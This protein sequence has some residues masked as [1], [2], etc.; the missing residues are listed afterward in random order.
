MEQDSLEKVIK[1][2]VEW[3]KAQF[4]HA[5]QRSR[6]THLL[7]EAAELYVAPA[8]AMEAADIIFLAVGMIDEA[9]VDLLKVLRYKLEKNKKREWGKVDEDGVVE[10]IRTV[11]AYTPNQLEEIAASL[12]GSLD[13]EEY[14]IQAWEIRMRLDGELP[15]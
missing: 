1:E 5:T 8:D 3:Q 11:P 6:A 14:R 4:P 2:V 9:G 12:P 7:K 10:H 13:D 15:A